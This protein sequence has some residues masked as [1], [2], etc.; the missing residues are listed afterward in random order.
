[1]TTPS[2]RTLIIITTTIMRSRSP[3]RR[4]LRPF[5]RRAATTLVRAAAARSTRN[6]TGPEVMAIFRPDVLQGKVAFVT[7]GGSG[8]GQRIAERYAEH[9][10]RV[11]LNGRKQ[12]KLD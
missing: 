6:V 3:W 8:I 7:G 4:L 1:M 12:E 9:G 5:Q 10:A 2:A 11:M